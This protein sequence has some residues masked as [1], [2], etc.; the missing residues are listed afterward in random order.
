MASSFVAAASPKGRT[1]KFANI[2]DEFTGIISAPVVLKQ[3]TEFGTGALKFYPKSQDPIM[4]EVISLDDVS[5]PSKEEAA[6]TIYV[7][8][9]KM[10]QAIGEAI[11]AAGADDL[12]VGGTLQ[13]K[14]TGH[15][16]GK[17]PSQPPKLYAA[18]YVAPA[19][20]AGN[21]GGAA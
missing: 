18:K 1:V 13:L 16:T 14:F 9:P 5:A 12:N 20:P 19:A 7:S 15:G 10:R 21:W 8:S 6:S 17:N 4:E 2:G 11:I 3:A